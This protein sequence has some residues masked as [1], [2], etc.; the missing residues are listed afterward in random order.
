MGYDFDV[1]IRLLHNFLE[2]SVKLVTDEGNFE[3]TGVIKTCALELFAL[4]RSRVLLDFFSAVPV[5]VELF[6]HV[7]LSKLSRGAIRAQMDGA[8]NF[9]FDCITFDA[10]G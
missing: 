9:S 7:V 3:N 8:F 2:L 6:V 5:C 10:V 4:C 1:E